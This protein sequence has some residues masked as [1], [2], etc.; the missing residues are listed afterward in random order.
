LISY[1]FSFVRN[2]S[3]CYIMLNWIQW[4][5]QPDPK[6]WSP[7]HPNWLKWISKKY[8][9]QSWPDLKFNPTRNLTQSEIKHDKRRTWLDPTHPSPKQLEI[10]DCRK[11]VDLKSN[12]E[13]SKPEMAWINKNPKPDLVRRETPK[14]KKYSTWNTTW[15]KSSR[16]KSS[17]PEIHLWFNIFLDELIWPV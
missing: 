10:Q 11:S 13:W 4:T 1:L 14:T 17:R 15:P 16:P 5:I 2:I 8:Y 3:R 12:P 9:V 6:Y 7:S